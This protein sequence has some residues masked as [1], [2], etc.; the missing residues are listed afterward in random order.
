MKAPISPPGI[1][2]AA[3]CTLP[4]CTET[5]SPLPGRKRSHS[6]SSDELRS[7]R[8]CL[9]FFGPDRFS[10]A[11]LMMRRISMAVRDGDSRAV[12]AG[13]RAER[14]RMLD[15]FTAVTGFHGKHATRLRRGRIYS[16]KS[17]C[18]GRHARW[19]DRA[20]LCPS[21]AQSPSRPAL[22]AAAAVATGLDRLCP[23]RM[24]QRS[25]DV[26]QQGNSRS[27]S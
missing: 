12:W 22:R 19:F 24:C 7:F 18:G 1:G 2:V 3:A 10:S 27:T 25:S 26:R 23:P 21:G 17:S 8:C 9:I 5:L 13:D 16:G 11:G 14:G 4:Q 15:E 20:S 6:A